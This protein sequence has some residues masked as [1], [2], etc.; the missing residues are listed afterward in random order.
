MTHLV[1][2]WKVPNLSS[3]ISQVAVPVEAAVGVGDERP[4]DRRG[5]EDDHVVRVRHL[6]ETGRLDE[7]AADLLRLLE[8]SDIATFR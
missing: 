7:L 6:H 3:Q 4:G 1:E 2:L 8:N 5:E